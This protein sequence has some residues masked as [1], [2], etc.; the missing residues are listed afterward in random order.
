[1][2]VTYTPIERLE[3]AL[4]WES[5]RLAYFE[6]LDWKVRVAEQTKLIDKLQFELNELYCG[7]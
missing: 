1:M 6:S 5:A 2:A 7:S 3:F 4:R